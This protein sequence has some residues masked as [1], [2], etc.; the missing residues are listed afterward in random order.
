MKVC[1]FG[2]YERDY[3]RNQILI[4]GL[5]ANGVEVKEVYCN[6]DVGLLNRYTHLTRNYLSGANDFSATMVGY[7]FLTEHSILPLA[8]L[9][10][11]IK[12]NK[13]VYD[14]F[15][16]LY[17]TQVL[18]RKTVEQNSLKAKWYHLRD[19]LSFVIPDII[20]A[21]T[22][23]HKKYFSNEFNVSESKFKVVYV[24]ADDSIFH[25]TDTATPEGKSKNFNVLFYGWFIPLHGVKHIITAAKILEK[26]PD[27]KFTIIG[28]GTTYDRDIT[29]AKSIELK[30]IV[31]E[32]E[33]PYN[34]LPGYI[35]KSDV[36]LGIFGDTP[37]AKRVIPNKAYEA[38]AMERPLI[39]GDSPAVREILTN[40][41]DSILCEMANPMA[42]AES[43][44]TLKSDNDLRQ[45]VGHNGYMLF[46]KRFSV[47]CTGNEIRKIIENV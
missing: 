41:K 39:T 18:D 21:D 9:L 7:R 17:D 13:L 22:Q 1:Y 34:I 19:K 40:R 29:L 4:K 36:C 10:S 2:S 32:R 3:P 14:P 25:P 35:S 23:E 47:K 12:N 44:L 30:N 27:I 43:I 5:E 37:K 28:H 42:L 11:G 45:R 33:V 15:V 46:K 6:P 31:F 8:R 20:L 26:Y 38:L 16:S 24:G